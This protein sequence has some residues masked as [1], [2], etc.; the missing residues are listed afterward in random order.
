MLEKLSRKIGFTKTEIKVI[1]FLMAVFVA[2]FLYRQFFK[3]EPA[4]EYKLFDYSEQD[5]LFKKYFPDSSF[6]KDG[7]NTKK[8]IDI[9]AE[10]LEFNDADYKNVKNLPPL[11]EKSINLNTA[12]IEELIRLPGIGEKTAQKIIDLRSKRSGFKKIEELTDV[13]GIG[14]TK[15]SKIEKFLYIEQSN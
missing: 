11:E 2:G 9:K 1:F 5:S 4:A 13:K 8:N 10:V 15:L 3:S 14:K 7:T 6:T 12:K